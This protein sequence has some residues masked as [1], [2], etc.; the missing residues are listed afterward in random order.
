M[1]IAGQSEDQRVAAMSAVCQS[2][3]ACCSYSAEWPRFSTEDDSALDRIPGKFVRP[4]LSGMACAGDR[5]LALAGEVG[6]HA[7]CTI[8]DLRPDVCRAC[9][10]GDEECLIARQRHA[11][12][13]LP[14]EV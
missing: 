10:P 2:C 1:S 8:Y 13:P 3:G 5:C 7:T 11:L 14:F 4:D 6:R 9:Q 12:C